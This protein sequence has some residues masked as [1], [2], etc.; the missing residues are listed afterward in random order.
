MDIK[1]FI[2][3]VKQSFKEWSEDKASRLAAALAYY[4]IFSI[5]P[6]LVIVI[7]IAGQFFGQE[8]AQ[9]ELLSQVGSTIGEDGRAALEGILEGADRPQGNVIAVIIGVVTLFLGA[10]G[11]FAQLQD[12][13]NTVW[14]VMAA[15]GRG[16]IGTLKTRFVSFTMVLGTGFLLLVSLVITAVLAVVDQYLTGLLPGAVILVRI[17]N[18]AISL[19]VIILLFALIYKVV[20]DVE[21][22]WS[23]VWIGATVTAVLFVLGRFAISLYLQYS[24]PTSTFGAAG[25]LILIA[26]WVYYSAQILFLGAE[27][28]QVYANLY[29]SD[30]KPERGAVF[31]TEQA[32]ATQ[33]IPSAGTK[34]K[35]I[36]AQGGRGAEE[37]RSGGVEEG[38]RAVALVPSSPV[39]ARRATSYGVGEQAAAGVAA[40]RHEKASPVV[41]A[42]GRA[43]YLALVVPVVLL[44]AWRAWRNRTQ[45]K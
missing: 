6:L 21:I 34:Q 39:T 41:N 26:I 24:D 3:L 43:R 16:I 31:M 14:D 18:F 4:T 11:V 22:Q 40:V 19:G 30:L 7:A 25:S 23:D 20:P 1:K 2:E 15:P 38:E 45:V 28:T 33:G 17:V 9:Q 5:P 44:G 32:R 12:G 13:L 37:R 42:L 8:A 10:S 36:E 27:F 29:G 35:A